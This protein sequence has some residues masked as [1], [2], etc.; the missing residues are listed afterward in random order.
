[1][2]PLTDGTVSRGELT[3]RIHASA[4]LTSLPF[5]GS[6]VPPR[7]GD[8]STLQQDVSKVVSV[9]TQVLEATLSPTPLPT[10][11]RPSVSY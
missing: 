9:I 2:L 11:H 5:A 1:M 8:A 6:A 4:H 10:F 7:S 3:A